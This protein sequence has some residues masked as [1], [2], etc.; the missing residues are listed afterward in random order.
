M[1]MAATDKLVA[2]GEYFGPDGFGGSKGNATRVDSNAYRTMG[3]SKETSG[4]FLKN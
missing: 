4:K 2:G 1:L 3:T